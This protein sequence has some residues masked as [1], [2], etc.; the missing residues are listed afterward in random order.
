MAQWV[1]RAWCF[2]INAPVGASKDDAMAFLTPLL[3]SI[4]GLHHTNLAMQIECGKSGTYHIQGVI[5]FDT[6]R[7]FKEVKQLLHSTAHLEKC[8][9]LI[10]SIKYC[11]KDDNQ[12]SEPYVSC[13][14]PWDIE[15][16]WDKHYCPAGWC[17]YCRGPMPPRI[18][19]LPY[20]VI[21]PEEFEDSALITEDLLEHIM[22]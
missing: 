15:L 4:G 2:T 10:A 13:K 18:S 3:E 6:K 8:R 19:M 5:E 1:S 16:E 20:Q 7:R 12:V 14:D 11:T 21:N 22:Y 9:D 17:N